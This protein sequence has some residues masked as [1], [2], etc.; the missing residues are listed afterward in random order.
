MFNLK[1]VAHII[2]STL[3]SLCTLIKQV[4]GAL[5]ISDELFWH[6]EHFVCVLAHITFHDLTFSHLMLRGAFV[7]QSTIGLL[8][9]SLVIILLIVLDS[10]WDLRISHLIRLLHANEVLT[11]LVTHCR[12]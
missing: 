11:S 3:A 7:L 8:L 12:S 4:L 5:S 1:L 2:L 9:A 6:Q 10:L